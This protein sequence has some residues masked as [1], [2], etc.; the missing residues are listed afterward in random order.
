MPPHAF[1]PGPGKQRRYLRWRLAGHVDEHLRRELRVALIKL[2]A[3][4]T[5]NLNPTAPSSPSLSS[6]SRL[7]S[8]TSAV[9]VALDLSPTLC[10]KTILSPGPF[11]FVLLRFRFLSFDWPLACDVQFCLSTAKRLPIREPAKNQTVKPCRPI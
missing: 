11:R 2:P 4:H 7:T 8:L 10:C 1:Q 5:P 6:R 9:L 3:H